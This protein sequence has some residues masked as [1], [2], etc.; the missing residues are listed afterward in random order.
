MGEA[1]LLSSTS[2][3]MCELFD[4]SQIVRMLREP[5]GFVY[6]QRSGG[7]GYCSEAM[8][9]GLRGASDEDV[10]SFI[11]VDSGNTGDFATGVRWIEFPHIHSIRE[12]SS[13]VCQDSKLMSEEEGI[14]MHHK[15]RT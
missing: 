4:G 1:K 12:I 3:Q 14:T 9:W 6:R 13:N 5:D 15:T 11:E 7:G 8:I 2:D 10:L